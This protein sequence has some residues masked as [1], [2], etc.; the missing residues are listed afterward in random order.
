MPLITK[1]GMWMD[2]TLEIAMDV[3]ERRS[4]SLRRANR[5]WNIP[6]NSFSNHMNG[7]TISRKMG[8]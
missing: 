2:E 4:H 7:K 6:M 8:P 1:R 5:L 3:V